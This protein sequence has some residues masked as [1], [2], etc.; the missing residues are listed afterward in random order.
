VLAKL[1]VIAIESLR[2]NEI[3]RRIFD[4]SPVA[5]GIPWFLISKGEAAPP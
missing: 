3:V 5:V 4:A 2:G 1:L